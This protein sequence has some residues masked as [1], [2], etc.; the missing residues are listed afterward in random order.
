MREAVTRQR[1]LL[2][3]DWQTG[4]DLFYPHEAGEALVNDGLAEDGDAW[5]HIDPQWAARCIRKLIATGEADWV[6]TRY[7]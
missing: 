7:E 5:A 3:L 6:G 2:E 4:V 1:D